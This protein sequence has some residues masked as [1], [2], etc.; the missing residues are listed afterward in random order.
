[1][2][3][4]G[5]RPCG[6][7]PLRPFLRVL[8]LLT[9]SALALAA[10]AGSH[11]TVPS[12]A[13]TP[14][15]LKTFPPLAIDDSHLLP[16]PGALPRMT[17]AAQAQA[18]ATS[19]VTAINAGG[20]GSL[21]ALLQGVLLSGVSVYNG[22]AP[23][24][25]VAAGVPDGSGVP[26]W[27]NAGSV[28]AA[29]QLEQSGTTVSLRGY[30]AMIV[31]GLTNGKNVPTA[32]S[33]AWSW[34]SDVVNAQATAVQDFRHDLLVGGGPPG[35]AQAVSARSDYALTAVQELGLSAILRMQAYQLA[36]GLLHEAGAASPSASAHTTADVSSA[37]GCD[38]DNAPDSV[39]TGL[40]SFA[41]WT[42]GLVGSGLN[43]SSKT[44]I[45][46]IAA[47]FGDLLTVVGQFIGLAG[48]ISD[49]L[50]I[51][52]LM[53]TFH[54]DI[55]QSPSPLVRTRETTA[56]GST[57]GVKATFTAGNADGSG[58]AEC[59]LRLAAIE[60][61]DASTGEPGAIKRA[62]ASFKVSD[63]PAFFTSQPGLRTD[64]D[65]M[66]TA[67]L[68]GKRQR[69][70]KTGVPPYQRKV[71][72]TA[73]V[74]PA[75]ANDRTVG[76][77]VANAIF[78]DVM[79]GFGGGLLGTLTGT[80]K[81]VFVKSTT[82]WISLADAGIKAA[83]QLYDLAGGYS[84][85]E[86]LPMTDYGQFRFVLDATADVNGIRKSSVYCI[87]G[88]PPCT[89]F[90]GQVN[91]SLHVHGEI[92]LHITSWH[93][94]GTTTQATVTGKGTV[95]YLLASG[96]MRTEQDNSVLPAQIYGPGCQDSN[97]PRNV[98]VTTLTPVNG[99]AVITGS[100][101]VDD[102]TGQ[103]RSANL[104]EYVTGLHDVAHNSHSGCIGDWEFDDIGT[105]PYLRNVSLNNRNEPGTVTVEGFSV[106][107]KSTSPAIPASEWQA[108]DQTSVAG[109]PDATLQRTATARW[110]FADTD[111]DTD[112]EVVD[113]NET[114]LIAGD[115]R[116]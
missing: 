6:H 34:V 50:S 113:F 17:D 21:K 77:A 46:Q 8:A 29:S 88:R 100:V 73:T 76:A 114:D 87:E 36:A 75:T 101:V 55:S 93:D 30:V 13:S 70:D 12:Q 43:G 115:P 25:L 33:I 51:G 112:T 69:R 28:F 67:T 61:L 102:A 86:K 27:L 47:R 96:L 68:T 20:T 106:D 80:A 71:T 62:L 1:M 3:E 79:S 56:D 58:M 109:A 74:H 111:A 90:S 54:V 103:V 81:A 116:D 94:D 39:W 92:P 4:Y 45:G 66:A 64:S 2:G 16:A 57:S 49:V 22:G 7:R 41:S 9:C 72:V 59:A 65:G 15:T 95:E 60:G 105:F 91:L 89:T 23:S 48:L 5:P 35:L 24:V 82:A 98:D 84:G 78:G 44:L 19:V 40:A 104:D 11:H 10:C 83:G 97:A 108:V 32:A 110:R 63:G 18:A 53:A 99:Q 14:A 38:V 42:L 26:Y 31:A 37:A 107:W 52:T 85:T